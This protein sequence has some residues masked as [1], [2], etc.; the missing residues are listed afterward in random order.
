[1]IV[2]GFLIGS[3]SGCGDLRDQLRKPAEVVLRAVRVRF[4]LRE[5]P[6]VLPKIFP[7]RLAGSAHFVIGGLLSNFTIISPAATRIAMEW[8]QGTQ[9][10][11]SCAAWWRLLAVC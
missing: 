7:G 8:T 3:S 2:E 9:I 6:S 4:R 10:D 5:H 1:V 11:T